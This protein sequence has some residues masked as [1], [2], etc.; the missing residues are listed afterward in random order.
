MRVKLGDLP[1]VTVTTV[2][3]R[4]KQIVNE[5]GHDGTT[6]IVDVLY[7]AARYFRGE[8]VTWGVNRGTAG[9][10]VKRST[11]VSHPSSYTGG[12]VV[13]QAG[14]TDANLSAPE[15]ESERI[16]GTPVYI[17]PIETS[18]QK[19]F[20]V[21]LTD[22]IAN[23]NSSRDLIEDMVGISSCDS[24]LPGGGSISSAERCGIDLAEFLSDPDND[25]SPG[26]AGQNNVILYTIG[27]RIS[28]QWLKDLAAAGGGQFFEAGTTNSLVNTF[29]SIVSEIISRTSS[30]A[31][32][33]LS[34]NSFNRLFHL[35]HVY[36]SLFEPR[37]QV[38]WPGNVK[39][40]EI[41]ES[42]TDGC[43][44]GQILDARDPPLPA[45]DLDGRIDD[46][47]LSF[48][49]AVPDGPRVLE[50]GAGAQVPNHPTRRVLTYT[51]TDAP[52]FTPLALAGSEH[53]VKDDNG[54]GI[55]DGLTGGTAD[56]RL[57]RT[58]ELLGWPGPDVDTL[59]SDDKTALAAELS[60]HIAW[61][62]GQDVDDEDRDDNTTEDRWS[63]GDPLHSS[64][65]AVTLGGD[66]TTPVVKVFVGTNEGAIRAIN[67][68]TGEEEFIFYPQVL[69]PQLVELRRN[70][71]GP[72][73]YGVDGTPTLWLNDIDGDGVIEGGDGDFARL[74]VGM[75]RG[76]N[77]I[78][79]LDVTPTP[80][81]GLQ[82]A[83]VTLTST[84]NPVYMWRIQGSST[85][86]PRLGQT[87]S[88]PLLA[89]V[90][91]GNFPSAGL[92]TSVSVL[93]F[94]GGYDEAQDGGFGPGGLGNAIYMANPLTG[95]RLLS[96]S[97]NDPGSGDRVVVPAGLGMDFPI[98]S[99]LALLDVNGDGAVDRIYVGDTGGQLWRL[100][101]KP[102]NAA[103]TTE[104]GVT[105]VLAKV[106]TVSSEETLADQRKFFE[107]P[108]I[109]R[110]RG[111]LGFSSVANYDLVTIV[112]G[113]RAHPLDLNTQDRYFAF[114]DVVIGPPT[115]T[116]APLGIADDYVTLQGPLASPPTT[117]DL[118][119]VTPIAEVEG[120]DLTA[121]QGANGYY[122]DLVEPG[123]KGL[124]SPI[125]LE[126]RVFFTTYL[127]QEVV[128]EAAC[129]LVEGAGRLYGFNVLNGAAVFNWD[130]SP[131][132][133][134]FTVYDRIYGLGAGIPSSA[135]PIFQPEKISLLIGGSG[136]ASVVDPGLKLLRQRTFWFEQPQ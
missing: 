9:S 95:Q 116:E 12:T 113:N 30:F 67:G 111:G 124:S 23:R 3:D 2:R 136:G 109:V 5:L 72:H 37:H 88:R 81:G 120:D 125:I 127:P 54:D 135:V 62:R 8:G 17:S 56:E 57:Q 76:G 104:P 92:S 130:G 66:A 129:R 46:E 70:P 114:R 85:E 134:P 131:E 77:N 121:L 25:Q 63:F 38:A 108:D 78:F 47:A 27:L 50:G 35:N 82:A 65:V 128:D 103:V 16:D 49:T 14:C 119:D 48:W 6:P 112:S 115:D 102:K 59:S 123:E 86:F 79:A 20:I 58:K 107:P 74:F 71:D 97:P 105:A 117:G 80:T 99:N 40:F 13:R 89:R 51:G 75:R 24:T 36:F 132:S 34:V 96:V 133:E 45:L 22:G 19:N 90:A 1:G 32:P 73:R 64:A 39:K 18:C 94:A 91:I 29:N 42:T 15:C 55:L 52:A 101:L 33:T 93:L 44:V 53:V 7:E 126:G 11:R 106:G 61:I 87:W 10:S 41:C 122:L 60:E 43:Q 84:I 28:N 26:V 21:L 118:F 98:P 83:D 100:D 110:V 4:L 68:F 69:L 31:T